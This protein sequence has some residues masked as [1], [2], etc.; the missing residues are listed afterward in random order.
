[1]RKVDIFVIAV[2]SA[3]I[4]GLLEGLMLVVCR[5]FP[6]ILAPYKVSTDALWITPILDICLF[7]LAAVGILFLS[8]LGRKWLD[9]TNLLIA[10]YGFFIFTGTFALISGPRIIHVFSAVL[11]SLGLTLALCRKLRGFESRL[12]DVLRGRL[13]WIP[14][15]IM[16]TALGVSSYEWIR[17]YWLF[18][19]LSVAKKGA[20]N[21][22]VIVMD[23]VRYDK[24]TSRSKDSLTPRLDRFIAKGVNFENAWATSSWSLPSHAS[25]LTGRYPHE[26]GAD[27]PRLEL[28]E[29]NTTLGEFFLKQG[30]VTGAFSGN[31]SWVTPEYLGRGFLRF[32][33]YI[34]E[35]ILR[36]TVFGR[37]IGR[38]LW[39]VGYHYAGRGKKAPEVNAQFLKFLDDYPKRPFFAYLCYMD[40]NQAF[41]NR[42]LNR[43]F[44]ESV[45]PVREVIDAYDQGLKILDQQMSD[46]FKEL[47]R[48]NILSNTLLII[49]SDHGESFG[50]ESTD[51]HDPS[52]HGTS[53]YSEQ[54]KVP[55]FMIYPEKIIGGRI[56]RANVSLRQI[57]KTITKLL[58]LGDSPFMGEALPIASMKDGSPNQPEIPLLATLNYNNQRVR[59]V[60]WYP[61]Q[62]IDNRNEPV[63]GEK[64]FDLVRDPLAEKNL[65]SSHP[66]EQQIR[67]ILEKLLVKGSSAF[68]L[69]TW[70][71]SISSKEIGTELYI[72][73]Q[74]GQTH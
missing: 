55:L 12:T 61:W 40:V 16:S 8:L 50:A 34:L 38:L 71:P 31:A 17:E 68:K 9:K 51:D 74:L 65:R 67:E 27:W 36:R 58:K 1:M 11:L 39:Q 48:R 25:I 7:S 43:G 4:F 28:D 33:V 73:T 21:V 29:N 45:P 19:Q 54:A 15:L 20:V 23:T 42:R 70:T 3:T 56:I 52:G 37:P 13:I 72:D 69:D 6:A 41:H 47:E 53:L 57:P 5:A 30:Y 32:D 46:L 63:D 64:L 62:Y 26:H 60:I 10:I 24:F 44:W 66:I 14:A 18:R 22:L 49:T 59:S 35:D 2:W